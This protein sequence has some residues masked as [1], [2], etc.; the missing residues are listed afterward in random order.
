MKKY[1]LESRLRGISYIQ[2]KGGRLI[3]LVTSCRRKIEGGIGR[4]KM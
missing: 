4:K 3:G 2:Y 1:C